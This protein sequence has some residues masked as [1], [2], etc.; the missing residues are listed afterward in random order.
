[1]IE[2]II[3]FT[4]VLVLLLSTAVFGGEEGGDLI[5]FVH[6]FFGEPT[7]LL[8]L[9]NEMEKYGYRGV[10]VDLPL[11]LKKIEEAVPHLTEEVARLENSLNEKESIHF[12]G[13]STGGLV[14]RM[15]LGENSPAGRNSRCVLIG[16]P[17]RGS[18]L[19]DISSRY[20]GPVNRIF[21]T[22]ESIKPDAVKKMERVSGG[23]IE[24]GAVAGSKDDLLL[25][26]L[27]EGK[28]DGRVEVRSVEYSGLK[29]FVV[30][31]FNHLE[32]IKRPET[33]ELIDK[34]LRRGTFELEDKEQ[35]K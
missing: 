34:F 1:M 16:T 4:V 24:I 31:P 27:L 22:L 19:A 13:H 17:N 29:D 6:G 35:E 3:I 30:L 21:R 33:A 25:G 5:V 7:D 18:R 32:L 9:K 14:I 28:N 12:V 15:Y 10:L 20:T 2:E 26:G 11:S 8:W 23:P